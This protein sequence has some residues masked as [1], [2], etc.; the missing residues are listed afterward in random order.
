MIRL[1][2]THGYSTINHKQHHTT[3]HKFASNS[4]LTTKNWKY[5]KILREI[6]V[7]QKVYHL[8]LP[9]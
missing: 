5:I 7:K 9:A 4:Q 8:S 1:A 3:P 2:Y 6:P